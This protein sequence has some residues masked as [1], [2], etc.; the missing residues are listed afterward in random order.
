MNVWSSLALIALSAASAHQSAD[1]AETRHVEQQRNSDG[2]RLQ[3]TTTVDLVRQ[4]RHF[5]VELQIPGQST[6]STV[7]HHAQ[8]LID[9]PNGGAT[10]SDIDAD[11]VFELVVRSFCGAGPNCSYT[12]FK[13][14]P[15]NTTATRWFEGGYAQIKPIGPYL[16]TSNRS[17]CCSWSHRVLKTPKTGRAMDANNTIATIEVKAPTGSGGSAQCKIQATVQDEWNAVVEQTP[18]LLSLCETYGTSVVITSPLSS[19]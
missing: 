9:A 1:A 11:G 14:N 6:T 4:Q 5:S 13:I 10:L 2:S 7:L 15:T 16:V 18:K 8:A 17:S 19:R 12:I 3:L